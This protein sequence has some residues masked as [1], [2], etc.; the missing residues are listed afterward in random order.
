[1]TLTNIFIKNI[2][3][4]GATS[5]DKYTDGRTLYLLVSAMGK[6]W[7]MDYRLVGKRKTLALALES[8]RTD[9]SRVTL[10]G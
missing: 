3:H 7:R 4:T 10:I 1:M 6:Y 5:G 2:Q 8:Y 9:C